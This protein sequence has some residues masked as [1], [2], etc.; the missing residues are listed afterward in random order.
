MRRRQQ[1]FTIIEILVAIALLGI[2]TAVLTATLTG[3]LSLNRQA[4]RQ[5]DTTSN[6]QQVM[7]NVRDAWNIQSNYDSACT[8][9]LSIPSG[10]TVKFIN[11]STRAEP[12]ALNNS[13]LASTATPTQYPVEVVTSTC[14]SQTGDSLTTT[15]ASPPTMRRVIVQSGTPGPSSTQVTGAQDVKLTFDILRPQE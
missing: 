11:L 4:Q 3:S 13:V 12:V 9:G 8:P 14:N 2:L 5:L 7:E 6:V 10:Y 1:G 15:P